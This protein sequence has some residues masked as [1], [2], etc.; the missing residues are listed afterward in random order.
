MTPGFQPGSRGSTGLASAGTES[1]DAVIVA[2]GGSAFA[3]RALLIAAPL[4]YQLDAGIHL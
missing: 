2:L 1:I 4:A 3:D